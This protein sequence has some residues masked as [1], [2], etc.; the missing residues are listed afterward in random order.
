MYR[1]TRIKYSGEDVG[2]VSVER[3][4]LSKTACDDFTIKLVFDAIIEEYRAALNFDEVTQ[5][6]DETR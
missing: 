2:F 1:L 3:D 5:H 4:G 6:F